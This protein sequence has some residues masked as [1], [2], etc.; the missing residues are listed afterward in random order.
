MPNQNGIETLKQIKQI[1]SK[2]PVIIITAYAGRLEISK[3]AYDNGCFNI[4]I[5]PFHLKEI[6]DTV[7]KALSDSRQKKNTFLKPKPIPYYSPSSSEE[8]NI[9]IGRSK[10]IQ[11]IFLKIV[12]IIDNDSVVLIQ[13]DT[14]TGKELVAQILHYR[15]KRKNKPFIPINCAAIPSTLLENELFG[16]EENAYTGALKKQ[17]GIFEQANEGTIF[18]DEIGDMNYELQAKILRVIQ[19]QTFYRI[20]G[21]ELIKTNARIIA[22]TNKNL[23]EETK[24]ENFRE[25]LYYRLQIL[26][27]KLPALKYRKEDIE[28]LIQH[29]LDKYNQL[30]KKNISNISLEFG[31]IILKYDWPGNIRQLENT[32]H[33]AVIMASGK[34][35]HVEHLPEDIY[36]FHCKSL[37]DGEGKIR[38]DSNTITFPLCLSLDKIKE[39][40][41]TASCDAQKGNQ[42]KTAEKLGY[43]RNSVNR[44]V[45]KA[46]EK[47]SSE[48]SIF[49]MP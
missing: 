45:K 43:H 44:I 10:E 49:N 28:E 48:D 27:I 19:T 38:K 33:H 16:H 14:G 39:E 17:K 13:G 21:Y 3:E 22:A 32:I 41:V 12:K 35:L 6:L 2:I 5:K 30:E 4:I 46:N 9:I 18:L 1:N 8:K 47:K 20:G 29:F 40:Y 34:C 23:E 26:S 36:N 25:D 15:S 42:T 37:K 24:K 11:K 7:E 31:E